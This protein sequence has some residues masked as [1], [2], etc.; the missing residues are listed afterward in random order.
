VAVC[1]SN[2]LVLVVIFW[3]GYLFLVTL[4]VAIEVLWFLFIIQA[5]WLLFITQMATHHSCVVVIVIFKKNW[6]LVEAFWLLLV[7]HFLKWSLFK[8]VFF[9]NFIIII[10]FSI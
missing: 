5:L 8:Y 7:I 9:F 3:F 2:A 6:L 4:L 10:V 1:H